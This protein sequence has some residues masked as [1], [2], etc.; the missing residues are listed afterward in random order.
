[1]PQLFSAIDHCT[2]ST[3]LAQ[4]APAQVRITPDPK[5]RKIYYCSGGLHLPN[6]VPFDR[7]GLIRG[8]G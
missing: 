4:L 7:C 1:M 2:Y 3:T 6:E 5:G 8:T